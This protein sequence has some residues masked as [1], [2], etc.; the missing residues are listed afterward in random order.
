VRTP[1]LRRGGVGTIDLPRRAKLIDQDAETRRPEC[2]LKRHTDVALL[3]QSREDLL[4]AGRPLNGQGD[5]KSC[6]LA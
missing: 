4:R 6:G 5:K 3:S 2:R 1:V